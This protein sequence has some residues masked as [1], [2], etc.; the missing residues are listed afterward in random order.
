MWTV[1]IPCMNRIF[2]KAIPVFR[3][4]SLGAKTQKKNDAR[5]GDRHDGDS[6]EL[7]PDD[8]HSEVL[9]GRC[10]DEDD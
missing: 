10:A 4:K 1:E 9:A 5:S 3:N 8:H 7:H 6:V 2:A